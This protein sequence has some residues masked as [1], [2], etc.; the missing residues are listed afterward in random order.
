MKNSLGYGKILNSADS[1]LESAVNMF[2]ELRLLNS[3]FRRLKIRKERYE[4]LLSIT[5]DISTEKL[6]SFINIQQSMFEAQQLF[7]SKIRTILSLLNITLLYSL[8]TMSKSLEEEFDIKSDILVQSKNLFYKCLEVYQS[9]E[10][11]GKINLDSTIPL[12]VEIDFKLI[13]KENINSRNIRNRIIKLKS[14]I[15][16]E[17]A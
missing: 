10:L 4:K 16:S 5:E 17:E 15:F 11:K 8:Q 1:F 9:E 2:S 7:D 3:K 12:I 14:L 13:N 6:V